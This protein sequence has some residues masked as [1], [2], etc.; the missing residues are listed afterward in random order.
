MPSRIRLRRPAER[1]FDSLNPRFI[2]VD[3]SHF[4][5]RGQRLNPAGAHSDHLRPESAHPLLSLADW[6]R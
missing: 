5:A 6:S 3:A 1:T 4:Y 2:S